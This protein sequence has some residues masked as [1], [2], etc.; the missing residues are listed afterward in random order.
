MSPTVDRLLASVRR[1]AITPPPGWLNEGPAELQRQVQAARA[2][3][4]EAKK[5]AGVDGKPLQPERPLQEQGR[6]LRN[7]WIEEM[8]VTDQPLTERMVLFWHNHFTSSLHE[9]AVPA[10]AVPPE[11]AVPP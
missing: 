8:L 11:R 1:D 6:E 9:G 7:W 3:A 10:V 2:E 4:A 5:K